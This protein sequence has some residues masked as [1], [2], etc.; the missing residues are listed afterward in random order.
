MYMVYPWQFAMY[1]SL[2]GV[3]ACRGGTVQKVRFQAVR[4]QPGI[5]INGEAR[6]QSRVTALNNND[7]CEGL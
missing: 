6:R 2:F 7:Y 1:M 5:G 3:K 4:Q